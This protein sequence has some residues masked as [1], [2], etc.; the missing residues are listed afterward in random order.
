MYTGFMQ[1]NNRSKDTFTYNYYFP[2]ISKLY[3]QYTHI[4]A[5]IR[6]QDFQK[7]N[8]NQKKKKIEQILSLH[9]EQ[10]QIQAA[11]ETHRLSVLVP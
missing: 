5:N 3:S 7:K 8:N 4:F 6:T 9:I 11:D 10:I 2:I 1:Q